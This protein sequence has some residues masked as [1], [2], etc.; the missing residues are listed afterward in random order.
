MGGKCIDS[1]N[2]VDTVESILRTCG[3]DT[4][5]VN[6]TDVTDE[7]VERLNRNNIRVTPLKGKTRFEKIR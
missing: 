3:F 2:V 5:T 1:D 4:A 6:I 7:Q